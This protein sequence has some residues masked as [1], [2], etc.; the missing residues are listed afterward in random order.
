MKE[1]EWKKSFFFKVLMIIGLPVMLIFAVF[2]R[3]KADEGYFIEEGN[4]VY[5]RKFGKQALEKTALW[6]DYLNNPTKKGGSSISIYNKSTGELKTAFKDNGGKLYYDEKGF[7]LEAEDPKEGR[8]VYRVDKDGKDPRIL[9]YGRIMGL[10]EEGYL[11]VQSFEDGFTALEVFKDGDKLFW[12]TA[13]KPGS[14][15]E[16]MGMAD[17]YLIYL[18]RSDYGT[19]AGNKLDIFVLDLKGKTEAVKVG[20]LD[21]TKEMSDSVEVGK[22]IR[23]NGKLY[24]SAFYYGGTGHFISSG[25]VYRA[26]PKKKNSL[27]QLTKD[28]CGKFE[29]EPDFTVEANE[30]IKVSLYAKNEIIIQGKKIFLSLPDGGK[31]SVVKDYTKLFGSSGSGEYSVADARYIDGDIYMIV[32][33]QKRNPKEDIGW[34]EAYTILERYYVRLPVEGGIKAAKILYKDKF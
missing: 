14:Y 30:R 18:I 9:A 12:Q 15:M 10:S 16:Y 26:D 2:S 25:Y 5:I 6:G 21:L 33:K 34:R 4:K 13:D 11:T 24:F 22:V 7:Y 27:K 20:K 29:R 31:K 17:H 32:H 23:K 19:S 28:I 8:I 3:A 1:K